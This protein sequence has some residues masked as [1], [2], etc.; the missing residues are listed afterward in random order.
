[1]ENKKIKLKCEENLKKNWPQKI[2]LQSEIREAD[3]DIKQHKAREKLLHLQLKN[4]HFKENETLVENDIKRI[5]SK[6]VEEKISK[7]ASTKEKGNLLLTGFPI[8]T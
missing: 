8:R 1:M 6:I 5:Q 3:L 7:Q 2:K 4:E